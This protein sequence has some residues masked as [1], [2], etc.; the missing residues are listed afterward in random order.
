MICPGARDKLWGSGFPKGGGTILWVS[1]SLHSGVGVGGGGGVGAR[2]T[3]LRGAWGLLPPLKSGEPETVLEVM[4]HDD[5]VPSWH[6]LLG[7]GPWD[8]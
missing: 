2:S 8:P 1:I 3:P 5:R 7:R 4:S 6:S